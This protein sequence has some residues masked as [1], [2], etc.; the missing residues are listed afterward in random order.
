MWTPIDSHSD[1]ISIFELSIG[2]LLS[3]HW[4]DGFNHALDSQEVVYH[5]EL[6]SVSSKAT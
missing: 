4:Y 6:P 2:R 1:G 3:I 5:D